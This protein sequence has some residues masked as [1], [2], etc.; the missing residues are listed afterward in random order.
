MDRPKTE[1]VDCD[2]LVVGGGMSGCGVA[3]ETAFWAREHGL[4]AV[5]VEKA[6]IE[7]SGAVAMGL[8]A[9]NCYIGMK[10]GENTPE[11]FVRY[12]RNDLMGLSRE[13][14]VYDIARHVDATVH[15]FEDWGL[16]FFKTEDGRY[17]REGRW[18]IMIHGESYKPIVAEAAKKA[19]GTE[20]VFQRIFI[21]HLIKDKRHPDRIAGAVGFSVRD[22]II[23][24]FKARAVVCACG[25]ATNVWRPHAV[26]E[27]L[28]RIWYS[29]FNTGSVYKLMINAGAEL[30]QMEHRLVQTRFKDG[31]GPVGMWFLLFKSVVKN[32]YG[33]RYDE[34]RAD[35]LLNWS[36]YGTALPVPTPLRNHQML[37]D[38]FAG[39]GPHYMRTDEALQRLYEGQSPERI[40][41]IE[42]EAW[43]DFLDMTMSQAL[44]WASHGIDPAENPSEL[45]LTEPYLMGSHASACGAWVSGPED[46]SAPA[47]RW[48]YNRM[49][50]VAGLFAA[51]DG[52]SGSAHKF[53]SGS[54]TEGR[55]AGKSAVAYVTDTADAPQ[56]DEAEIDRIRQE[57]WQPVEI[58]EKAGGA[59]S[60]E[61]VEAKYLLPKLGLFRLQKIMD[62]YA[63]GPGAYYTTNESTLKRGLELLG[64]LKEDMQDLGARDLHDLLRCWELRDRALCA[65]CHM[66]H[67]LFRTETRWPGYLYRSDYPALDDENW[68]LFVNSRY[69]SETGHWHM[70]KK[71]FIPLID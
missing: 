62:E 9:I 19:I 16:P 6:A 28:G 59:A 20:N 26:G 48:G 64:E 37:Q 24:V 15:M 41:Q 39:K 52:V 67:V 51:G 27:G 57:I 29:V 10:W 36:P 45:T 18:Q 68:K 25:G 61:D 60:H 47:Y 23:Y 66:H 58:A 1:V 3:Y 5:V 63:A 44:L 33:E 38:I 70:S 8:S 49:T 69:D 56:V 2:V 12:V 4:R 71:P 53:S 46:L 17:V 42:S 11:D 30:S 54:F 34:T 65:E 40:R 32:A 50:T 35:E 13:D 43:E 14:L 22:P 55:L 31:Y 21:S 7:R